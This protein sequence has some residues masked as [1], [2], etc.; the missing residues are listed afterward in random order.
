MAIIAILA[1]LILAA[2]SGAMKKALRN[3][4]YG[5]IQTMSTALANYQT[6]NGS[7]PVATNFGS[8]NAYVANNV[9]VRGGLY[10]Q[11]SQELYL[12]L[13]GQTNFT[14]TPV[15]G[16][17]NYIAVFKLSQIGDPTG[18]LTGASYIKDPWNYSYGYSTGTISGTVTNAPYSGYGFF[19]L[20]STAGTTG[21]APTNANAWISNWGQQ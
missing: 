14:A 13:S 9:S 1:G 15:S 3:R 7:Y 12:A 2:G 5:E 17:K 10:Q 11:S 21:T 8:T 16:T 18:A 4:A 20:W 6:D 19:D